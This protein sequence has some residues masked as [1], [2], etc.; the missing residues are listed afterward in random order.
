MHA[1][2][3][4]WKMDLNRTEQQLAYLIEEIVPNVR[5][6]DGFVSGYWSKPRPDGVAYSFIVFDTEKSAAAFAD[7]VRRDPHDRRTTGVRGDELA[8][9]EIAADASGAT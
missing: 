9:V 3:G 6:A 1:V 2:V 4:R 8:M 5:R 7:S